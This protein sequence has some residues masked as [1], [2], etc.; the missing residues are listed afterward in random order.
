MAPI[1]QKP[2]DHFSFV[3]VKSFETAFVLISTEYKCMHFSK[4]SVL[5]LMLDII[6]LNCCNSIFRE[7]VFASKRLLQ[8]P[9]AFLVNITESNQM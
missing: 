4:R 2:V 6:H 1:S 5:G 3:F 8:L 7:D 9:V